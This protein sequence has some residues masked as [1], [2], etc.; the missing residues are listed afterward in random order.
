MAAPNVRDDGGVAMIQFLDPRLPD[1]F[2][3]KCI[4]EPNSG[5][6]L[7]IAAATYHD[8]GYGR[9]TIS[10]AMRAHRVAYEALCAEI[11]PG[12]QLDHLCRTPCC[13]NPAHLEPV[14]NAQNA[15]RG[16]VGIA[17]GAKQRAKTHCPRGHAYSV[18]NTL[19]GT[20]G[21]R[22]CRICKR[23]VHRAWKKR[24]AADV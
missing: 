15:R 3:E 11:P 24:M 14:T 19:I 9:F 13:V 8:G 10:K 5:C 17:S 6:W 23:A 2:W 21:E 12:L 20:K 22:V 1:R 4:P 18:D 16:M 7:W